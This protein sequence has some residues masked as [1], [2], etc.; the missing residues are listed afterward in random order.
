LFSARAA[1]SGLSEAAFA[2]ID[3]L[4]QRLVSLDTRLG[5]TRVRLDIEPGEAL[6]ELSD[7]AGPAYQLTADIVLGVRSQLRVDRQDAISDMDIP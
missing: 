7:F 5:N 4:V 1:A 2:P 3:P 6:Q